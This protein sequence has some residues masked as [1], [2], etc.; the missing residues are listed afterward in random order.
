MKA[1]WLLIL[2]LLLVG[3]GSLIPSPTAS[4]SLPPA[5]F[6]A[7]P[8]PSPISVSSTPTPAPPQRPAWCPLDA[9]LPPAAS[10]KLRVAYVTSGDLWLLDE[11]NASGQ[12]T[13]YGDVRQVSLSND[14][15]IIAFTRRVEKE[16]VS[17]WAIR[18][19]GTGAQEL[20][21]A[22]E[23][24]Q[25][26]ND[27]SV[28]AIIP[29]DL[30]W[31]PGTHTLAFNSFPV[32]DAINVFI[33]Y[34]FWRVDAD[35]GQRDQFPGPKT[36]FVYSPDGKQV[37]LYSTEGLSIANADGSNLRK[38]L[39]PAYRVGM[40]ENYFYPS[41]NWMQDSSAIVIAVPDTE[42]IFVPASTFTVWR[43]L[44]DGSGVSSLGT[45][46]GFPPSVVFSDDRMFLMYWRWVKED[47]S[48]HEL[49]FAR[50]DGAPDYLYTQAD[51]LETFNWRPGSY[52][53]VFYQPKNP[54]YPQLGD[55]CLGFRPI[56]TN[57]LTHTV[58]WLDA[59]R[60]CF[61]PKRMGAKSTGYG[62]ELHFGALDPAVSVPADIMSVAS[63]SVVVLPIP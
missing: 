7:S 11:G 50:L 25:M 36:Y 42:D 45:F 38:N 41:I 35:T 59:W 53:F 27:P 54:N 39:L 37:A 46:N 13:R 32:Y 55:V 3:C 58:Q 61:E 4:P 34:D 29:N 23:F 60:Y 47:S 62:F 33:P 21:S 10:G 18:S 28:L 14:G 6:T 63:Y 57:A 44:A 30:Q 5:T 56:V 2:T 12:L 43:V 49:H 22:N 51:L 40:G 1:I 48:F 24:M 17:L 16:K 9:P 26:G 15:E 20:I 19:D 8:P 52:E 31:I